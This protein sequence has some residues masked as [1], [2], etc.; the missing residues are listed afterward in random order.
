MKFAE[1]MSHQEWL[2]K[3]LMQYLD[4]KNEVF[5]Y[6][7]DG[8]PQLL[9]IGGQGGVVAG[10]AEKLRQIDCEATFHTHGSE[11][12]VQFPSGKDIV[13]VFMIGKPD[14]TVCRDKVWLVTPARQMDWQTVE[15]ISA[16]L[17]H[18]AQEEVQGGDPYPIWKQKVKKKFPVKIERVI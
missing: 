12:D 2:A 10:N 16:Q 7:K 3:K 6:I 14:Y 8:K 9:N 11:N 4:G 13:A 17:W 5:G 18:E 1:W 15:Q